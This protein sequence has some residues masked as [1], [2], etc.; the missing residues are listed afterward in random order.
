MLKIIDL[1]LTISLICFALIFVSR[2]IFSNNVF[3]IIQKII[4]CILFILVACPLMLLLL[5]YIIGLVIL[6]YN[7][8]K[9]ND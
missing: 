4:I 6:T 3:L 8:Y 7:M 1:L 9:P 5:L 2:L